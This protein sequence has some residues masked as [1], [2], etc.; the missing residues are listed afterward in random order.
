MIWFGSMAGRS[1][2][3]VVDLELFPT[4]D[5]K[6]IING[7]RQYHRYCKSSVLLEYVFTD[8]CVLWKSISLFSV[9]TQANHRY[10]RAFD[11][12]RGLQVP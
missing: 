3:L 4:L 11:F 9:I 8:Q 5:A 6:N 10:S 2:L 1:L 12:T 7:F